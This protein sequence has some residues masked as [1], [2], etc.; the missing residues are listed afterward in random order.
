M[1]LQSGAKEEF[2][3]TVYYITLNQICVARR[4][5]KIL[6]KL[7]KTELDAKIDRW[8]LSVNLLLFKEKIMF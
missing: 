8:D 1:V 7:W 2:Y 3:H 5:P 4:L 6:K